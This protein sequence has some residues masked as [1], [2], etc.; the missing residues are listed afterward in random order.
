MMSPES[1]INGEPFPQPCFSYYKKSISST[2][3]QIKSASISPPL[4]LLLVH[5]LECPIFLSISTFTWAPYWLFIFTFCFIFSPLALHAKKKI[6][7]KGKKKKANVDLAMA[8]LAP[9]PFNSCFSQKSNREM[10]N[11]PGLMLLIIRA[12]KR[13]LSR[14]WSTVECQLWRH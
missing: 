10:F 6:M 5:F 8:S 9:D 14:R 3:V 7:F 11:V 12:N 2:D 4:L 13:W 1:Q